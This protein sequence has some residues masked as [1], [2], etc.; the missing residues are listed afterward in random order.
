MKLIWSILQEIQY[1]F[2]EGLVRMTFRLFHERVLILDQSELL[3][4]YLTRP[5]SKRFYWAS[6]LVALQNYGS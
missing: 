3:G 6:G 4:V 1:I 2:L 5:A